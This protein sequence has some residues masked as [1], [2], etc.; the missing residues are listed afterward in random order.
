METTCLTRV[1]FI[2]S[3]LCS[4]CAM[5]ASHHWDYSKGKGG[6]SHWGGMCQHGAYQSPIMINHPLTAQ[7]DNKLAIHYHAVPLVI[8]NTGHS[9]KIPADKENYIEFMGKRYSLAQFHYHTP[10]ENRVNGKSYPDELHFVNIDKAGNISVLAVFV[11]PGQSNTE[12]QKIIKHIPHKV[13]ALTKTA[14]KIN[15]NRLLPTNKH[16]YYYF[17][18]S[19]TTPPCTEGVNWIVMKKPIQAS[20]RQIQRL[21]YLFGH[22]NRP[23]QPAHNRIILSTG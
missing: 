15:I 20:K 19:L 7:L 3:L 8:K 23:T 9:L 2:I 17:K 12:I 1:F 21:Q 10:S 16:S 14:I 22:N 18:G 4:T 6:P 13:G 5:A 11:T